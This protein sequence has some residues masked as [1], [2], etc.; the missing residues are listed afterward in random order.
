[1]IPALNERFS[2]WHYAFWHKAILIIAAIAYYV[3]T[4]EVYDINPIG[5]CILFLFFNGWLYVT[6]SSIITRIDRR[7]NPS[8]YDSISHFQKCGND[9]D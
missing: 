9:Y 1:M 7:K 6:L 4:I 5:A 2:S 3:V 8:F